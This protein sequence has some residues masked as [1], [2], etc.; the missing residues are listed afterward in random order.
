MKSIFKVT[1]PLLINTTLDEAE[2]GVMALCVE[3]RPYTLPLNFV[4]MGEILYFHGAKSGR[5]IKMLKANSYVSFNVVV[6]FSLI[7]SYFST[8]EGLACPATHFFKSITLEGTIAFVDDYDEKVKMLTALMEKLQPEGKYRP[9]D[10]RAYT[11]MINATV[12]YK[13]IPS[14]CSAKFKF[15]QHLDEDRF[16]MIL[17]HL[18]DRGTETDLATLKMMEEMR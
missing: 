17:K 7:A 13:L 9:L 6:P 8:T 18:H 14:E 11:T 16:E 3:N 5:K 10:E 15:G 2:Y 4:R 1:D 12:I